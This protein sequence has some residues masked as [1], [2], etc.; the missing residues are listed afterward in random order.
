MTLLFDIGNVFDILKKVQKVTLDIFFVWD[1]LRSMET[2]LASR[3]HRESV[4]Y[5]FENWI[6][7]GTRSFIW[8]ITSLL[9]EHTMLMCERDATYFYQWY[10]LC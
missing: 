6:G 1:G 9:H 8:A 4:I 5:A 3:A 2:A 7:Q 10:Q